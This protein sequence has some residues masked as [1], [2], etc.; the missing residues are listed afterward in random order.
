M[1]VFI[2]NKV[3]DLPD[4]TLQEDRTFRDY[5]FFKAGAGS[6]TS[7]E[8]IMEFIVLKN[9]ATEKLNEWLKKKM[10]ERKTIEFTSLVTEGALTVVGLIE[11]TYESEYEITYNLYVLEEYETKQLINW[12]EVEND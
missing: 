1:K 7:M 4:R 2:D 5:T 6:V 10:V 9:H 12:E 11:N 3:W 8:Y